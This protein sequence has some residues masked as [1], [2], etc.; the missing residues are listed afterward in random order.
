MPDGNIILKPDQRLS[1]TKSANQTLPENTLTKI[2][3]C[4]DLVPPTGAAC[5]VV[6]DGQCDEV[7][8]VELIMSTEI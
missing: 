7:L 3:V 4:L 5:Y 6:C 2:V 1:L 8:L